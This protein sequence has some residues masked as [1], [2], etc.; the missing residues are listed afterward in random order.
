MMAEAK[1]TEVQD[2]EFLTQNEFL[3]CMAVYKQ[4]KRCLALVCTSVATP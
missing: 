2:C 1:A 3:A 4:R